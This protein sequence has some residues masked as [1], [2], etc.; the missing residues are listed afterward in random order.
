MEASIMPI[1][2]VAIK[3]GFLEVHWYGII[4]GLGIAISLY[5]AMREGEKHG[6][7]KDSLADLMIWAIPI[8][9]II[10]AD[11]LCDLSVGLLLA[12]SRRI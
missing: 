6:I 11:L 9:I 7:D 12:I 8:A 2:P 4:I 10:S 5:L 1:N 3:F